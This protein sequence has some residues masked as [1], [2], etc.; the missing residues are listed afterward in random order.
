MQQHTHH[1]NEALGQETAPG[2]LLH[3]HACCLLLLA[4]LLTA[5]TGHSTTQDGDNAA[6]TTQL[7]VMRVK[8]CARLYTA[9][10]RLHKIVTHEDRLNLRGTFL[11]QEFDIALPLTERK[12][13][14]PM[15]ATLKAYIDFAD[16]STDNVEQHGD[17]VELTLPDPKVE[18]TESRIDHEGIMRHVPLARH[19]FSDAE[20]TELERE[21]RAAILA[22]VPQLGLID[23]AQENA[24]HALVPMLVQLGYREEDITITFRKEFTTE[25]L[26]T[27]LGI[28]T[29]EYGH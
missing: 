8:E 16:F 4:L 24:A 26:P 5:C 29:K 18:L 7:L 6:D 25:D 1:N 21:G 12:L 28:H 15:D 10:Y 2:L 3:H 23:V 9:E 13:A 11:Q 20:L 14:I 17:K 27:L 22:S 19:S